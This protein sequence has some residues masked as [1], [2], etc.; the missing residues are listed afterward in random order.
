[1][2][3]K[4]EDSVRNAIKDAMFDS[5]KQQATSIKENEDISPEGKCIQMDVVLDVMRFLND[6]E[7]NVKILNAYRQQNFER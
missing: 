7:E 4:E 1:M 5:L 2:T 3:Q 6:Y